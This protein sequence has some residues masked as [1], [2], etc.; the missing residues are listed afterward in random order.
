[1]SGGA[2]FAAIATL[3]VVFLT[4]DALVVLARGV[5][6]ATLAG[7]EIGTVLGLASLVFEMHL[8]DAAMRSLKGDPAN[9]TFQ[10]FA[11]RLAVVGPLTFVFGMKGSGVDSQAFALGYLVTFFVYLCWLTWRH[12]HAPVCYK[13]RSKRFAPRVVEKARTAGTAGGSR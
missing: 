13:G 11:M 1:V 7:L 3:L 6:P 8:I 5:S 9:A 12:Y 10:T 2:R 4:L